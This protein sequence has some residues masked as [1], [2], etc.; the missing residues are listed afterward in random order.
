MFR[1]ALLFQPVLY[2][3]AF[4]TA[5]P[6]PGPLSAEDDCAACDGSGTDGSFSP[7]SIWERS[8]LGGDLLGARSGLAESGLTFEAI[9]TQFYQGVADGG[10]N[11]DWA[12]GGKFDYLLNVDGQKA[13]LW[14]GLLINLHGESRLGDSVNGFDGLLTPSNIAMNFPKAE[15]NLSALT[16]VKITQVLSPN[17]AVYGGKINTLDEY[18]LRFSPQ[19]G[20]DRPGIGGFMNTSLVF[21]PILARTIPYAALGFGAAYMQNGEPVATLTVFDPQERATIGLEDPYA[22]GVVI[23]PDFILRMKPFGLPGTY[24]FGASYSTAEYLSVDPAAYLLVPN[25]GIVGGTESGSW[26]LYGNFY[27]A[28]WVDEADEKRSWGIFG[29]FGLSDGNPNP[30]RYIA[31]TGIAGRSVIPG[32]DLD[33]FGV[34]F[35]YVNLSSEF[36]SLAAPILP[37]QDEYGVELFY[38]VAVAPWCRLTMDLQ[39]A[40]PSTQGIETAV[41]PGLRMS[42]LF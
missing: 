7:D 39:V 15:G 37:Q 14:Q 9:G 5:I 17:F 3:A 27:Q 21:N 13:G 40:R 8:Q 30:V 18:P 31:N 25:L 20:L 42:I 38:N 19:L 34:G 29:Q 6:S 23:M 1:I 32:R 4:L 11:R 26:A 28:L 24:N 16:G 2:A 41:I 35:L 10:Q 22:R 36:K 12:Y 33:T